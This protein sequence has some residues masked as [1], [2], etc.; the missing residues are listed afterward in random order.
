MFALGRVRGLATLTVGAD[1]EHLLLSD[2]LRAIRLDGPARMFGKDRQSLRYQLEGLASAERGVL[3]LRRF[4]ALCRSGRFARSLHPFEAHERRWILML[5]A[6]DA[7]A[8]GAN[9]REIAEHILN[10]AP[11]GPRWRSG[12]PSL[13][14][15]AQR[16]VRS[17]ERF[18]AGEYL[19]LLR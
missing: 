2:G 19:S 15:R 3:T 5:R 16:L 7:I 10:P 6:W 18:A 9:Q 11:L 12:E 13:R 14:S 4:L 1:G 8:A 17:A